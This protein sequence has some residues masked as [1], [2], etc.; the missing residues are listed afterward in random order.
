MTN[1]GQARTDSLIR[2]RSEKE[3]S[4]VSYGGLCYTYPCEKVI[5]SLRVMRMWVK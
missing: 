5:N 4:P 2:R 1:Q 3:S